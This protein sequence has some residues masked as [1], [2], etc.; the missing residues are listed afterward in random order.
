[1][2]DINEF[3]PEIRDY[4]LGGAPKSLLLVGDSGKD[5]MEVASF[6]LQT[7]K[8]E[9]SQDY[10][11]IGLT[12]DEKTLGVEEAEMIIRRASLLPAS[13]P[14]TVILVEDFDKMTIPAQNKLLKLLEESVTSIIIAV[15]YEDTVLSTIKSRMQV[16]RYFPLS[17]EEYSLYCRKNGIGDAAVMFYLT[18]GMVDCEVD[19]SGE[20]Y[21]IFVAVKDICDKKGIAGMPD[22][23]RVLHMVNEKDRQG[24]FENNRE[25]AGKMLSLIAGSILARDGMTPGV[26]QMLSKY[27]EDIQ[28]VGGITYTKDDFMNFFVQTI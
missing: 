5:A 12:E 8:P 14:R 27:N 25:Y 26:S 2:K 10:M 13:N 22:I 23:M 1:M 28:R 7:D 15:A 19:R 21:R 9:M 4:L 16:V 17:A 3:R 6:L 24:F 18:G 11:R 20:I